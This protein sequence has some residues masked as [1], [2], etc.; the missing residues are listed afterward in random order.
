MKYLKS[1]FILVL[2][3]LFLI[4]A[5][6]GVYP[7]KPVITNPTEKPALDFYV[8]YTCWKS[9]FN[10]HEMFRNW[11]KLVTNPI[12]PVMTMTLV[13]NPKINWK[14]D[15]KVGTNYLAVP[16]LE[17]ELASFG[18]MDKHGINRIYVLDIDTNCYILKSTLI[19]QD[20]CLNYYTLSN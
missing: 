15:Y 17:G 8:K 1:I 13:G 4:S 5:C 6:A 3:S 12:S 11:T 9:P 16:V 18:Y 20:A 14:Q 2:S 19:E 7:S 10:P